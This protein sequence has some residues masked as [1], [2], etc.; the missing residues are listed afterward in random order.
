MVFTDEPEIAVYVELYGPVA[1][2]KVAAKIDIAATADG[3]ALV[4]GQVGGA[5]TTEPDKFALNAKIQIASSAARRL[6]CSCGRA[7]GG[8]A[9]RQ[10]HADDAEGCEVVGGLQAADRPA[11]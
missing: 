6:R 2:S 11:G 7:G 1:T 5:A 10:G 3:T 9:R 8:T 4:E